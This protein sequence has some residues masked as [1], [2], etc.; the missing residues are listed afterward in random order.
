MRLSASP[1]QVGDLARLLGHRHAHRLEG[2]YLFGGG[3]RT[4]GD[5]GAGMTHLLARGGL[6]PGDE[7]RHRLGHMV[8]DVLGSPLF[9]KVTIRLPG[10]GKFKIRTEGNPSETPFVKECLLD[11]KPIEGWHLSHFDIKDGST[12]T[13]VMK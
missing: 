5:D 12:L 8:A 1:E 2:G 11:G 7:Y 6:L 10:G 4:A 13:F 3:A 9:R